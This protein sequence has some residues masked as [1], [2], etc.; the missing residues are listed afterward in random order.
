MLLLSRIATDTP[1]WYLALSLFVLGVGMGS[2]MQVLVLSVQNSVHVKNVGVATSGTT[3]FRSIGGTFGTAVFGAGSFGF[4]A[5]QIATMAVLV[6][7]A[8]TAYNSFPQLASVLG[9]DG[10]LPRALSVVD[11][12]HRAPQA[13]IVVQ[14]IVTLMVAITGTFEQL[15]VL[16]NVSALALYFGCAVASWK[17]GQ[18][19]I[20]P[21]L[22]SAVIAWLFTGL[23]RAEWISF[24]GC[25]AVASA[26][27]VVRRSAAGSSVPAQS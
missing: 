15:A 12:I 24:I 27:Y 4:Y 21:I 8:N 3:F 5:L 26:I 20:V 10:F 17:L 14:S 22:A 6:L 25:I 11:P 1:Y 7:A 16:A 18:S 23:T 19:P 13:A 9:R 2:T